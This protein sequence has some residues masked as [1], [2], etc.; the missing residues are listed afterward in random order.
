M[1]KFPASSHPKQNI[2]ENEFL[3]RSPVEHK[4]FKDIPLLSEDTVQKDFCSWVGDIPTEWV[5]LTI[6]R[7]H[8]RRTRPFNH[9]T[10]NQD[11]HQV[12]PQQVQE[13]GRKAQQLDFSFDHSEES[14]LLG[15]SL[16]LFVQRATQLAHLLGGFLP[17]PF[18]QQRS[19]LCCN[20]PYHPIL[21]QLLPLEVLTR[22]TSLLE[23]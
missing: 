21:I 23:H 11:V 9:E 2:L 22:S 18:I 20:P 13:F 17:Y 4:S 14:L 12:Y 15:W 7:S 1:S 5:L 8:N 19:E 16:R 10:Q 6:K 3:N